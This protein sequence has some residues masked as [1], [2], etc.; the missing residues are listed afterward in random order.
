MLWRFGIIGN[1]R[2]YFLRIRIEGFL[3][4]D[5]DFRRFYTTTDLATDLRILTN[6]R[7]LND[8]KSVKR[9]LNGSTQ[10]RI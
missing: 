10:L 1:G 7:I 5:K 9:I 6:L 3:R 8:V 2:N 4:N